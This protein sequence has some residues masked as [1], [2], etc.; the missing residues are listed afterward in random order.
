[1]EPAYDN[2]YKSYFQNKE[3]YKNPYKRGTD[4]YNLFERGWSQALKRHHEKSI[5]T[6]TSVQNY[7]PKDSSHKE[8]TTES[9]AEAY[10][11]RKGY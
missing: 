6:S 3:K 4:E 8:T 9:S 11:R 2:G 10:A 1:M 7:L 5:K